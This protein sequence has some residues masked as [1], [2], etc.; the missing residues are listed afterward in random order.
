[1]ACQTDCINIRFLF[2]KLPQL[3]FGYGEFSYTFSCGISAQYQNK[4]MRIYIAELVEFA[5]VSRI[6]GLMTEFEPRCP[7]L[8]SF[9]TNSMQFTFSTPFCGISPHH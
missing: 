1:M 9:P 5:K 7:L 3:A 2:G 4:S 8:V 6:Y